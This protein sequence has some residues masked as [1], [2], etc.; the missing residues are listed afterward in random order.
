MSMLSADMDCTTTCWV[1]RRASQSTAELADL[2]T[3]TTTPS[4]TI[5]TVTPPLPKSAHIFPIYCQLRLTFHEV[6][7]NF[8]TNGQTLPQSLSQFEEMCH[9]VSILSPAKG[10]QPTVGTGQPTISRVFA[11][12]CEV[13]TVQPAFT[14]CNSCCNRSQL[15]EHNLSF[16]T[17]QIVIYQELKFSELL[18]CHS[19]D[20]ILCAVWST[21][22]TNLRSTFPSLFSPST[23]RSFA[24][25]NTITGA[26]SNA[27]HSRAITGGL[28]WTGS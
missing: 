8:S 15:Q 17:N 14:S 2:F 5:P 9:P 28:D 24:T 19:L 7:A 25:T 21:G 26:G 12:A 16:F 23:F 3:T 22:A 4:F 18:K 11:L 27:T 20:L 10:W 6:C 13:Y 1:W